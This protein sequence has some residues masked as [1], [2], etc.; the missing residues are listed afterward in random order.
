M[1][2]QEQCTK[3]DGTPLELD[4]S[5][6]NFPK[7]IF[8]PYNSYLFM[9]EGEKEGISK[10]GQVVIIIVETNLPMLSVNVPENFL[11]EKLNKNDD[12]QIDITYDGNPDDVFFSLIF[13]YDY[14]IV[15]TKE[16]EYTSFSFRIWDLFNDF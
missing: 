6:L 11:N 3:I 7:K 15:A 9:I 1:N 10:I 13:M 4:S 5:I 12:L 16:F 8:E 2:K 14:D